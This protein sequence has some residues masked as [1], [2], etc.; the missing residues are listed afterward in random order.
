MW[1]N[2]HYVMRVKNKRSDLMLGGQ[3]YGYSDERASD[4]TCLTQRF[5]HCNLHDNDPSYSRNH[6]FELTI[7]AI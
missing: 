6:G 4:D 2:D 1:K 5:H 3:A 7:P